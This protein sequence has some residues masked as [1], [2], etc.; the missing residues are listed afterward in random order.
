MNSLLQPMLNEKVVVDTDGPIVYLGTLVEIGKGGITL[1]DADVHDCRDGHATKEVYLA[2]A[3]RDDIAVNR[4]RV[5]VSLRHAL[6]VSRLA[7]V[8][9]APHESQTTVLTDP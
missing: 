8:V 9:R 5:V 4:N 2:E 1:T 3:S 7:D 6:S